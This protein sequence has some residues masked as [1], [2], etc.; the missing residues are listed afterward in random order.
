MQLFGEAV[1]DHIELNA[2][3]QICRE[4]RGYRCILWDSTNWDGVSP[5][6]LDTVCDLLTACAVVR[7]H[8][9]NKRFNADLPRKSTG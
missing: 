1:L 2:S 3:P 6:A 5:P 7:Q 4:Y 9:R 8:F